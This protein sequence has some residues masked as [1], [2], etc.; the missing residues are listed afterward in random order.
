MIISKEIAEDFN[1]KMDLN[2]KE[3]HKRIQEI[4][5]RTSISDETKFD[6][7]DATTELMNRMELARRVFNNYVV[8]GKVEVPD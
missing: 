6:M 7:Q 1:K 2:R 4:N 5:K 8:S 3:L